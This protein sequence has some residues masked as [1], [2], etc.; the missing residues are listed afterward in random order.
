MPA[1]VIVLLMTCTSRVQIAVTPIA[2]CAVD[3][4]LSSTTTVQGALTCAGAD[5]VDDRAGV[6]HGRAG[7]R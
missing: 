2:D 6:E 5:D 1:P 3:S 4:V 7:V